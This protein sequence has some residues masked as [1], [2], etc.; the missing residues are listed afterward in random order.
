MGYATE[1]LRWS[2]R[3]CVSRKIPD[4]ANAAR[5]ETIFRESSREQETPA[6]CACLFSLFRLYSST[7]QS[8]HIYDVN[9]I[10]TLK[11][12]YGA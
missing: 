2:L 8:N 6:G 12:C 7:Q 10:R 11:A 5:P 4:D 3:I 9:L 1:G